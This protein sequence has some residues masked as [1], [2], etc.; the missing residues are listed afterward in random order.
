MEIHK[1]VPQGMD[2]TE[3]PI[4]RILEEASHVVRRCKEAAGNV[5]PTEGYKRRQIEELK[6]FAFLWK[7]VRI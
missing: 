7:Q 1:H 3:P 5:E 4:N 6:K 2:G